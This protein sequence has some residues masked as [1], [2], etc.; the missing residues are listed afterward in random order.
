MPFGVTGGPSKFGH[1]TGEQFYNLIAQAILK[2][3]VDDGGMAS[4]SFEEGM[5][6]LRTLLVL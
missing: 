6:K 1:V 5:T 4:N 3:F 2:L